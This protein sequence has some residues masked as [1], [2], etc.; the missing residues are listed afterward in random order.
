MSE[1]K[2]DLHLEKTLVG[3][4]SEAKAIDGLLKHLDVLL[5]RWGADNRYEDDLMERYGNY[6]LEYLPHAVPSL[7]ENILYGSIDNFDT[8]MRII[9][10]S[11]MKL[12]PLERSYVYMKFIDKLPVSSITEKLGISLESL[13]KLHRAT[14]GKLS[15]IFQKES[16]KRCSD[17]GG[18]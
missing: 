14:F 6:E 8:M 10:D 13:K 4:L 16:I 11:I 1:I 12:L 2:K 7:V 3:M 15:V 18:F 5:E 17:K 9:G